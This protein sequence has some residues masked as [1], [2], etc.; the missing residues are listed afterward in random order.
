MAGLSVKKKAKDQS[1]ERLGAFD[2]E[3]CPRD[4]SHASNSLLSLQRTLG[5]RGVGKLLE[6]GLSQVETTHSGLKVS[7]P[8][9]WHEREADRAADKVM[10]APSTHSNEVRKPLK[11]LAGEGTD[12]FVSGQPLPESLKTSFEDRFGYDLRG[13]RIHEDEAAA[14]SASALRASAYTV[15]RNI[16][17]GASQYAPETTAGRRLLAH[18]LTHVIQQTQTHTFGDGSFAAVPQHA[19]L[20][21]RKEDWDFSRK[22]YEALVKGKGAFKIAA[23]SSWFPAQLQENLLN[24]LNFLFDPKRTPAGTEGVNIKDLYHGHVGMDKKQHKS[25]PQDVLD[26]RAKFEE[27]Q[28]ELYKKALGGDT[29]NDV[30]KKNVKEFSAAEEASLPLAG[31]MLTE[32]LKSPGVVCVYHTFESKKPSDLKGKPD[33]KMGDPR[34]NYLTPLDTNK[35]SP[36]SAPDPDNASSWSDKYWSIFQFSFLVDNKGEVHVRTGTIKQ[37]SSVT[38]TPLS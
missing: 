27:K 20:I 21:Q 31:D 4:S 5:N 34:R 18:E 25:V 19:G 38:G 14:Q 6:L 29:L 1:S 9:D 10:Q 26:K 13:V 17:F 15:G 11:G 8:G 35:P 32:V 28:E 2:N 24:T 30:T 23:D 16:V 22:D 3:A 36:F 12:S 37:L 7:Q 33:L